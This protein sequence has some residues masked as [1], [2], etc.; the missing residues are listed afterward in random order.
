[1]HIPARQTRRMVQLLLVACHHYQRKC[2]CAR[3]DRA[4]YSQRLGYF[5]YANELTDCLAG[6][7]ES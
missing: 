7:A 3:V 6:N 5:Q 4:E 1:M 2:A